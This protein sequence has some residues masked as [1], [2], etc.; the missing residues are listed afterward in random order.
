M[1]VGDNQF[2]FAGGVDFVLDP[3]ACDGA[4]RRGH[5]VTSGENVKLTGQVLVTGGAICPKLTNYTAAAAHQTRLK[6]TLC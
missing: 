2:N 6:L 5:R 3:A 1:R 4:E